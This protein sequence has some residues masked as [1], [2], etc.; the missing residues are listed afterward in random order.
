MGFDNMGF[1]FTRP[2][3]LYGQPK[4]HEALNKQ[5]QNAFILDVSAMVRKNTKHKE[6]VA[7][8]H[9]ESILDIGARAVTRYSCQS[10]L[11]EDELKAMIFKSI[12]F[13]TS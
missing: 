8:N 2:L 10:K 7:K 13:S 6:R 4:I 5:A 3:M 9:E 1:E 12:N 11:K